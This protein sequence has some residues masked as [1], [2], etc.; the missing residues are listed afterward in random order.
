MADTVE[1]WGL[2]LRSPHEVGYFLLPTLGL[3]HAASFSADA[4][5]PPMAKAV[6][7]QVSLS[8]QRH[9][10]PVGTVSPQTEGGGVSLDTAQ[11]PCCSSSSFFKNL[12]C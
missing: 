12:F 3:W 10:V 7:P 8:P 1:L 5:F 6:V 9:G 11:G 4:S 2:I